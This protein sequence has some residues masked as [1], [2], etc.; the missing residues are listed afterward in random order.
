LPGT[1]RSKTAASSCPIGITFGPRIGVVYQV[2]E[3]T[4]LRGGYGIFYNFLDRIRDPCIQTA[5]DS[6]MSSCIP[7]N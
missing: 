2:T 7:R 3:Q 4:V 5:R 6:D 1:D